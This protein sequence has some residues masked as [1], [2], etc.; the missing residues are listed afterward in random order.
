MTVYTNLFLFFEGG[1][2]NPGVTVAFAAVGKFPW[3]KVPVYL[4]AQHLGGFVASVIL[5]I[6][7]YGEYK[8]C[9]F[10]LF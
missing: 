6:T 9:F 2:I 5:Y 1:H 10:S 4:L 7:Y 8:F 3:K